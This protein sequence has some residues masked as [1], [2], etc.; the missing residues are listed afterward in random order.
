MD[1][2]ALLEA[3]R[4]WQQP[5]YTET[6]KALLAR[7]VAEETVAVPGLGTMLLPGKV[8]FA[9]DSGWRFNPSY[10]PPQLATYFVR[11]GAPWPA[12]RDSNLRLLL[13]TAPKALPGLGAL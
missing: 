3:G 6:G 8:G 10:L 9:D 13:E 11:F 2:L 5:Q 4:L 7:I 1:S 12:L